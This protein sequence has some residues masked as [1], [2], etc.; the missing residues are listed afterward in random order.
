MILSL[1]FARSERAIEEL[2]RKYGAPVT[3]VAG[4]ILGDRRDTEECVSDTWL[5]AWN[6]IPPER[7]AHLRAYLAKLTSPEVLDS[8][9]VSVALESVESY[10]GEL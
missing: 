7:P 5:A 1:F 6:A 4:G 10:N 9:D 3:R 2:E 8:G